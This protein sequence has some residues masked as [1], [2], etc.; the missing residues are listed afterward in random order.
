[1][2]LASPTH[3]SRKVVIPGKRAL[4][5][6]MISAASGCRC[7]PRESEGGDAV[8]DAEVDHLPDRCSSVT[9]S[10]AMPWI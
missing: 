3:R 7:P 4:Y 5:S 2:D 9:S 6:S 8:D 10:G 1:M